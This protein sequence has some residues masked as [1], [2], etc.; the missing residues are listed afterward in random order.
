MKYFKF[1]A[2]FSLLFVL[3]SCD[4]SVNIYGT[5]Q[6]DNVEFIDYPETDKELFDQMANS[7][8]GGKIVIHL[9]G[10]IDTYSNMNGEESI[11]TK[12]YEYNGSDSFCIYEE[13]NTKNCL[14]ILSWTDDKMESETKDN[15]VTIKMKFT[16]VK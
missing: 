1:F 10:K 11:V 5:W 7:L 15:D 3:L 16:R 6:I 13:D 9:D 14:N 12:T 2:T 8:K 4:S